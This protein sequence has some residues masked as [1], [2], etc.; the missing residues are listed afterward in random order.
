MVAVMGMRNKTI[1]IRKKDKREEV[2]RKRQK[3]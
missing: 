3:G 2:Y 1:W